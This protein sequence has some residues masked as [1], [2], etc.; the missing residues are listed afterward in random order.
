MSAGVHTI[1]HDFYT[2]RLAQGVCGDL[3][4]IIA[5]IVAMCQQ[6]RF[7]ITLNVVRRYC[8]DPA[9]QDAEKSPSKNKYLKMNAD[10]GCQF[11]MLTM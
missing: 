9:R 11:I 10:Y 4:A 1:C 7:I 2:D 5:A 8:A 3:L 6:L